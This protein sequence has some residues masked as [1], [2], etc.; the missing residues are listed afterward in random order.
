VFNR[1][2]ASKYIAQA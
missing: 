2:I 1:Q